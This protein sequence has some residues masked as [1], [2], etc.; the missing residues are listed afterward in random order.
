[1][2]ALPLLFLG[3]C[4]LIP[5]HGPGSWNVSPPFRHATAEILAVC[6]AI[7]EHDGFAVESEDAVLGTMASKWRVQLSPLWHA[8]RRDNFEV[9][10]E[11]SPDGSR[12][13]HYRTSREINEEH[14]YPQSA[15]RAAW[16]GG[17]GDEELALRFGEMLKMR[18]DRPS[19]DEP[20]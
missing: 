4:T 2:R 16:A 3:A 15:E 18:L 10:V 5:G 12:V 14:Q 9:R 7:L 11:S 6:R 13:V 1:M 20:K 17:G 19:L 8:G